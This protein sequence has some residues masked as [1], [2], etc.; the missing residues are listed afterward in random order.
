MRA[1]LHGAKSVNQEQRLRAFAGQRLD[2]LLQTRHDLRILFGEIGRLGG[3]LCD[4]V[5]LQRRGQRCSPDQLPVAI[6]NAAAERLDVVDNLL[7]RRRLTFA[8]RW[9]DVY[10]IERLAVLAACARERGRRR[11]QI[12]DVN[13]LLGL[14]W[15]DV[16]RPANNLQQSWRFDWEPLKAVLRDFGT[17]D[18][19][20]GG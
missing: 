11:I 13:E 20:L 1:S 5:E 18:W 12:D 3:I 8:K 14:T 2:A 10:A 17:S 4:V 16:A 7:A 6:A 19:I 15:L 9:P